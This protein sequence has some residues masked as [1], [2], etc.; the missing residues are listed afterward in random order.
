MQENRAI[1]SLSHI[2][3]TDE[4]VGTNRRLIY[5]ERS[6]RNINRRMKTRRRGGGV[7][8][9]RFGQKNRNWIFRVSR[10]CFESNALN[11]V[12][13]KSPRVRLYHHT[14]FRAA[15]GLDTPSVLK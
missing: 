11:E 1:R 8:A 12:L 2:V 10:N 9:R 5:D 14:K 13:I 4:K 7:S 6:E 15:S 3:L